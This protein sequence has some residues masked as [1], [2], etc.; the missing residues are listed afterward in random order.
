MLGVGHADGGHA[1][2]IGIPSAPGKVPKYESKER[3]SCITMM[4]CWILWI[5]AIWLAEMATG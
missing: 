4:T 2:V 5:P 3:F 1:V